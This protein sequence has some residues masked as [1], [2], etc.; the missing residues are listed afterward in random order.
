MCLLNQILQNTQGGYGDQVNPW[1]NQ[2]GVYL[3][4]LVVCTQLPF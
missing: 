4:T 3:I 1:H 2:L